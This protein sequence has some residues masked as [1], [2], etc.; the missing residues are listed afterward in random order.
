MIT[1][2]F[3]LLLI[4][5]EIWYLTSSQYK[6]RH[7]SVYISKIISNGKKLRIGAAVLF[8]VANALMIFQL[9]WASGIAAAIVGIMAAGSLIVVLQPFGYM[10]IKTISILYFTVLLLEFF[11]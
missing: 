5:F 8:F 6:P 3:L 11:I 10:R 4:S 9:G 2:I 7:P 1:T